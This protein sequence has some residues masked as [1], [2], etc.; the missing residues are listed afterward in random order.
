MRGLVWWWWWNV[1]LWGLCYLMA[2][3]LTVKWV[4]WLVEVSC[5]YNYVNTIGIEMERSWRI[6][7]AQPKT[8]KPASIFLHKSLGALVIV[9]KKSFS[10]LFQQKILFKY[11]TYLLMPSANWHCSSLCC[12][13][14]CIFST[15]N[16][17][18]MNLL[19]P[20]VLFTDNARCRFAIVDTTTLRLCILSV[21][22]FH[23][24]CIQHCS[25]CVTLYNT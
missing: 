23:I 2:T 13:K 16:I 8:K 17:C 6:G 14:M 20:P 3:S 15:Y 21:H 11:A 19:C 12:A 5:Q 1:A 24:N 10:K 9:S 7:P 25:L 22:I 4:C 18:I